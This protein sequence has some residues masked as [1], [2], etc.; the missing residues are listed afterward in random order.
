MDDLQTEKAVAFETRSV[1]SFSYGLTLQRTVAD[2]GVTVTH[3]Y[4]HNSCRGAVATSPQSRRRS[5]QLLRE[6]LVFLS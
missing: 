3:S 6:R 2:S 4:V 1:T 5:K